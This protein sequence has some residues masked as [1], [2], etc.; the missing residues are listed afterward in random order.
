MNMK[1]SLDI[2]I[3]MQVILHDLHFSVLTNYE[4]L[5]FGELANF[6]MV[7]P[8]QTNMAMTPEGLSPF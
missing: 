2:E 1:Q 5:V 7:I 6:S 3:I 4:F 8:C